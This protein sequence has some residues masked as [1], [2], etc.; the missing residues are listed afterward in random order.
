KVPAANGAGKQRIPDEQIQAVLATPSDL[1]AD[2][3]GTMSRRVVRP[4]LV[5]AKRN[6]LIRRVVDING[7]RRLDPYAELRPG[8]RSALVDGQ[9][10]AMQIDRN[11]ECAPGGAD[12][13]HMI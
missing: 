4:R 11:A 6:H 3:P 10:I 9:I 12:P 5:G 13:G 8:L 2:S 1:Q 7:R